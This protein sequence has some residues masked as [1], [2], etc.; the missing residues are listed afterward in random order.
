MAIVAD[1][2]ETFGR[3]LSIARKQ[4]GNA[5]S[6]SLLDKQGIFCR[7]L[8]QTAPRIAF[9]FS[10]QGSQYQGMLRQ[11]VRED[12]AAAEAMQAADEILGR[13]AYG[14]FSALAWTDPS[15]LGTDVW[16]TQAAMLLADSI[17]YAA[18]MNRQIRPALVLGHSYGEYAALFAAG[19]WDLETALVVTRAR[20]DG[21]QRCSTGRGRLLATTAEPDV[22]ARIGARLVGKVFVANHNAPDQTVVGG[23]IEALQ[24][25]AELLRAESYQTRQLA[26]PCPFHTP[27]M[28]DAAAPLRQALLTAEI[29][30]PQVPMVSVV[31]NRPVHT[32]DEIRANLIAHLTTPVRYVDLIRSIADE[33]ETVFVEIGPGQ[34]LT[35]LHERILDGHD[36][37]WIAT[38]H[39][40]RPGCEQI[41]SVQ[42]LLECTVRSIRPAHRPPPSLGSQPGIRRFPSPCL[43]ANIPLPANIPFSGSTRP[44]GG[45]RRC[46][47][48]PRRALYPDAPLHPLRRPTRSPPPTPV[49]H[50][51]RS[52]SDRPSPP[53]NHFLRRPQTR[54]SRPYQR[55]P[56][57]RSS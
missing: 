44:R 22:V 35:R 16:A 20:C 9:V 21:I 31:T 54:K 52:P 36:A 7:Q 48:T 53:N 46:G 56:N 32:P 5:A 47:R 55:P 40:K 1:T 18:V 49:R 12:P 42:A 39:V 51:K 11:L 43:L 41:D 38:D 25:L 29:R 13:H 15:P 45:A 10:G 37:V 4:A 33:C 8:R 26:V 19:A 27:L 17:V 14:S 3:K 23:S 2:P 6:Q 34:I 28:R 50:N 30:A 57:W 24:Q